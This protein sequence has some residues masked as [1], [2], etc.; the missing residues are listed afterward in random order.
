MDLGKV[1]LD[2]VVV[3]LAARLAAE[4]AERLRQ[5]AVL[6]E[7]A[8]GIVIGPSALRLIEPGSAL[9]VVGELGALLL[10]FEV[11]RQMDLDDLR[12]VGGAS[13]RVAVIGVAVPM[14][15]GYAGMRMAGVSSAPAIFLA[16]GITATSVGITARVFG[17]LRA[18]ARVEARTV[19][20][21]AVADDV[22][23]L[24]V[25]TAVV[26]AVS[27]TGVRPGSVAA[28]T[29][30]A[31]AFVGGAAVFGS[32]LVPRLLDGLTSRARAEGTVLTVGLVLALGFA[33]AAVAVQLAPIVGAFVAGMAVGRSDAAADLHRRLAP[34]GQLLIPV[35]FLQIGLDARLSAFADPWVLAVAGILTLVAVA[36]KLVSGLGAG[37]RQDR[38]LVG[39]GMVPRGEVGLIFAALGLQNGVLDPRTYG[40]LLA[41]VLATTV[42]TPPWLR[43]RL[44][45]IRRD[46]VT[47][48][49][50]AIEPP[51]GWLRTTGSEVELA[52]EPPPALAGLLALRAALLCR[53]RRPGR[54]L[55]GWLAEQSKEPQH[56][57]EQVRE[58]FFDLLLDGTE[59]SWLLLEVGQMLPALSPDLA[60]A[61]GRRPRDPFA[62][63]PAGSV[64]FPVLEGLREVRSSRDQAVQAW[65]GLKDHRPAAL[66]ALVRSVT[67]GRRDAEAAAA[68]LRA[69]G[70]GERHGDL[71]AS[72]AG[73]PVGA[74]RGRPRPPRSVR[75]PGPGPGRPAEA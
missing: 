47:V 63:E 30:L 49:S 62:L 14:A 20:G 61:I 3:L 26:G 21:A 50:A 6:A 68:A 44:E 15:L 59:R 13:L 17:D 42:I 48:A 56:W 33:R 53:H 75:S 45:R 74:G 29:A 72:Q 7:I 39:A 37:G 70:G 31:V 65:E 41:V 36:G 4:G 55:V 25:L 8:I 28:M 1:L 19:L 57:N 64:R 58:A 32:W 46:A 18:L 43:R 38:L 5:P 69:G 34:L 10:L 52:G 60:A 54:R 27:G 40:V 67:S 11:G 35:F 66:A 22:I 51:Q 16:G 23:G 73:H 9:T 2:L 24:L 71:G 12:H